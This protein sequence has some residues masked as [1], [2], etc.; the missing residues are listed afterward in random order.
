MAGEKRSDNAGVLDRALGVWHSTRD[1]LFDLEAKM[2][3]Q[4]E[5]V[6]TQTTRVRK[7][8]KEVDAGRARIEALEK[9]RA[10]LVAMEVRRPPT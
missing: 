6:E 8:R 1:K 2:I 3:N 5:A 9:E 7:L 10:E 4:S